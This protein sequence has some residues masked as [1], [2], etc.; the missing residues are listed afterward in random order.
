MLHIEIVT[1]LFNLCTHHGPI[2]HRLARVHIL[3]DD[4]E[5][6]GGLGHLGSSIGCLKMNINFDKK[7]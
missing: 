6:A 3:A 2:C 5:T 4:R 7:C 1:F